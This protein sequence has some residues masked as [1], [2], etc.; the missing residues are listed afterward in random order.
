MGEKVKR[1]LNIFFFRFNIA[2]VLSLGS[3]DLIYRLGFYQSN[4]LLLFLV[5]VPHIYTLLFLIALGL[6]L[7]HQNAR[8]LVLL[9]INALIIL[10]TWGPFWLN[11]LQIKAKYNQSNA[12]LKLITWNVGRMGELAPDSIGIAKKQAILDQKLQC[13]VDLLVDKKVDLI[14]FQEISHLRIKDLKKKLE[15]KCRFTDYFGIN[16]QNVG[17]IAIC[18]PHWS[19]WQLSMAKNVKILDRWRSI[20]SEVQQQDGTL[21]FNLLN[22]HLTSP[23]IHP[24]ELSWDQKDLKQLVYKTL[25]TLEIHDKQYENIVKSLNSF[26]D[27]TL[28]AGDFNSPPEAMIHQRLAEGW[29]DIWLAF[30]QGMGATRYFGNLLPFRIDYIYAKK[31]QWRV[32]QAEVISKDCSDHFPVYGELSLV[33]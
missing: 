5:F 30:G 14:A 26:Q 16:N 2:M 12:H 6:W 15:M 17:G 10:M 7:T 8:N 29:T 20:F 28:I 9:S 3:L 18:I 23:K 31:E 33:E 22:L 1:Y 21:K 27:P 24:N 13:V 11:F 19:V 32:H 25:N 4:L